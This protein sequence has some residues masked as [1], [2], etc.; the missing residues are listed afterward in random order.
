MENDGRSNI[1]SNSFSR[2]I[3]KSAFVRYMSVTGSLRLKEARQI[4]KF[5]FRAVY[6]QLC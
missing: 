3:I 4:S 1:I 6:I 2:L 5:E